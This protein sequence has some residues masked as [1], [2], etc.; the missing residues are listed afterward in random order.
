M[1]LL[2]VEDEEVSCLERLV[3]FWTLTERCVVVAFEVVA[4]DADVAC[5]S[6]SVLD[7]PGCCLLMD[8]MTKERER[9]LE[10][11]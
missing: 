7:M 9:P 3:I 10:G 11:K 1:A 2:A 4:V 5:E 8:A 6:K